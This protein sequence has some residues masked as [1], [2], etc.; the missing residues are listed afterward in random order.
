MGCW[1]SLVIFEIDSFPTRLKETESTVEDVGVN[2]LSDQ[3]VD[4]L[5]RDFLLSIVTKEL[6]IWILKDN[7]DLHTDRKND[8]GHVESHEDA[9]SCILWLE[10]G[11]DF[12]DRDE[13]LLPMVHV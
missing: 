13:Q 12:R 11:L 9:L 8:H 4:Q 10:L 2:Q 3:V 6:W 5:A 1:S 7:L